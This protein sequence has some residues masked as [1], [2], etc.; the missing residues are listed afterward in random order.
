MHFDASP[1]TVWAL[2]SLMRQDPRVL[3]WTVLKLGD[4]V[5]DIAKVGENLQRGNN[6][7]LSDLID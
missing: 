1:R 4:K 5:E 3:R 6:G 7:T 2:K